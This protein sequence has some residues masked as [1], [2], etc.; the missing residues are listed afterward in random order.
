MLVL[1]IGSQ[2]LW[3]VMRP[4]SVTC[5]QLKKVNA[6]FRCITY[7]YSHVIQHELSNN[8]AAATTSN[9]E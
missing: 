3:Q 9:I 2:F 4:D 1:L 6:T 5:S 8:V 7:K